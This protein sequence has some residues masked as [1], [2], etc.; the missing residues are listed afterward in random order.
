MTE[1]VPPA[2]PAPAAPAPRRRRSRKWW[3]LGGA[4]VVVLA[5]AG[6]GTWYFVFRDDAPPAVDIERA[7]Q[8]V[9]GS[10][11]RSTSAGADA[12]A[13]IDGTWAV[14][15]SLGSFSD[16]TSSFAGYRVREELVGIGAKTAVGRTPDVQGSLTINGTKIPTARFTVDLSTLKSDEGRRDFAIRNQALET[17]R[18]PAATFE[19]T[20]PITLDS[21]PAEGEKISVKATGEL[22]LHGVTRQVTMPLQAVR[23]G[24]AIAVTG[25]LEIPFADFEI[26]QPR[27]FAVLSIDDRG[28]LEVQL[29]FTR[30]G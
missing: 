22:T 10:S 20:K 21:I 3:Y 14:D 11:S 5:L 25:Q 26:S 19:L 30:S 2:A 4:L 24:E 6:F 17:A 27:S 13:T 7:S 16:V 15:R 8:S 23:T 12:S 9:D 18:F 1:P 28:I 29:F